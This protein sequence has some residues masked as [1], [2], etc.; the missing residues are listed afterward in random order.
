M[1]VTKS[2]KIILIIITILS[3][4]I[5][6]Y[7]LQ[8][9]RI[10]WLKFDSEKIGDDNGDIFIIQNP[11]SAKEDL[12]RLIA[13]MNDTLNFTD[14][15]NKKTYYVQYF[16]KESFHLNRFF[17]PYYAPILGNYVDIRLDNDG[18]FDK[19]HLVDYIYKNDE[20]G[21]IHREKIPI[22]PYYIFYE[23]NDEGFHNSEY[24]PK[25]LKNNPIN[26]EKK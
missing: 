4:L 6:F 24:Y 26:I 9:T 23:Y 12:I 3:S 17:N 14:R 15:L 22:Y 18:D 19:E 11:P 2:L 8:G 10:Y 7:K 1:K 5:L 21:N 20:D 25:G 13:E 16:Y